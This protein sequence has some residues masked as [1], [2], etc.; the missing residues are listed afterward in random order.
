MNGLAASVFEWVRS[1]PDASALTGTLLDSLWEGAVVALALSI[2]LLFVRSPRLR[3]AASCVAMAVL[4]VGLVVTFT[5]LVP[6]RP[7]GVRFSALARTGSAAGV[8]RASW[9]VAERGS[10]EIDTRSWMLLL[11]LTGVFAFYLRA[12]V[13]WVSAVKI[14]KTGVCSAPEVWRTRVEQL[15]I[16]L[17][18]SRP[19]VLLE[20]SLAE[21][22]VVVG[23]LRPVILMPVGLLA[24]L[25]VSQVE[26]IL[27]HELAHIR[28]FDSLVNLAQ[29]FV[30]GLLFYHPAVWW[31]SSVIRAERENCCDEVVV[32]MT[33]APHALAKALT[34]LEHRRVVP[35]E[36]LA[37][38]GSR[39]VNRVARL[40]GRPQ[41]RY[42]G[43]VPLMAMVVL[44]VAAISA[45]AGLQPDRRVAEPPVATVKTP[46]VSP[47]VQPV[48][49]QIAQA[50]ATPARPTTTPPSTPE[51]A[52]P[53][54]ATKPPALPLYKLGPNDVVQVLVVDQPHIS[55]T[56]TISAEGDITF[57]LI[58]KIHSQDLSIPKLQKEIIRQLTSA[59]GISDPVVNV[60]LL[61]A[62]PRWINVVGAVK[63]PVDF[64][65]S[66]P[67]SLSEALAKAGWLTAKAGPNVFVTK[68][69]SDTPQRIGIDDLQKSD[70]NPSI[71]LTLTGGETIS[72]PN[73]LKVWVTG[74]VTHPMAI[75]I[76]DP[77]DATVLKVIAKVD[78]LT[79]GYVVTAY[80]YRA[81][82][83][84][85][86]HEIPIPLKDIK[87][88]KAE[89]VPLQAD[90]IILIP[91]EN[92][93][94]RRQML[95]QLQQQH[96]QY[97]DAKPLLQ[98]PV[99][100]S[101]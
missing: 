67:I 90:D 54:P 77:R 89:D 85:Q 88:R 45:T 69:G 71:N 31:I 18:L 37:A 95:N 59:G 70:K 48:P 46:A 55:G 91:D 87:Y 1:L 2:I 15:G 28:R 40:L 47:P 6:A 19:V 50:Q 5:Q 74:H 56:Y 8:V 52:P 53:T 34:V 99:E 58:K 29:I 26:A 101:K 98:W 30:E 81:D 62:M 43:A 79:G 16:R 100:Q 21:V 3:Y 64:V 75:E 11:W 61:R 60:Q 13:G 4:L 39:L 32:S 38:T 41:P 33:G 23:Y 51:N 82:D 73:D 24:G 68:L 10:G 66:T 65:T 12:M 27:T 92:G 25:P 84:G 14:R 22:P 20:S 17:R 94:S 72:V 96:Q 36:A 35:R 97:Y 83:N 57:P 78:G 86:R 80:I 49:V 44:T 42:A 9:V 7:V 63:F 93:Y 76:S